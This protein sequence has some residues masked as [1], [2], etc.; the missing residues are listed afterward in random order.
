LARTVAGLLLFLVAVEFLL[1]PVNYGILIASQEL[2]RVSNVGNDS[3]LAAGE[4][5]WLVWQSKDAL[6]YLV[7]D[8]LNAKRALISVPRKDARIRIDAYDNIF[9]VLFVHA[10]T[11]PISPSGG[12]P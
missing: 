9:R 6:T 3:A 4:R 10:A 8:T 2:P 11:A 12:S 5:G 7:Q 1:L